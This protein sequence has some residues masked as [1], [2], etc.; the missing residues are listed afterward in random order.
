MNKLFSLLIENEVKAESLRQKLNRRTFFNVYEAFKALDK[1]DLGFFSIEE[2]KTL[3]LDHGIH[4]GT[5]DVAN[6]VSRYDKNQDGKITYSEFVNEI[7]P[8]SPTKIY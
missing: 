4:A 6:L 2:F 8:V 7:M 1:N 3:L 5:K